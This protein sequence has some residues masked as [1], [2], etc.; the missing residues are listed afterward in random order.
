MVYIHVLRIS[1]VRG[2]IPTK[3]LDYLRLSKNTPNS[4]LYKMRGARVCFNF[5]AS[6]CR[7]YVGRLVAA[8]QVLHVEEIFL[9]S[10]EHDFCKILIL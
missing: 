9:G 10:F 1:Y 7:G 2:C 4:F 6:K 3:W 5:K 8:L